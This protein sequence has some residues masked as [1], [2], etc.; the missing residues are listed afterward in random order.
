MEVVNTLGRRKS[1]IA[2]IYVSEGKGNITIN[3][4]EL[5]D[6][7][8][9][10]TLQYIVMQ[11]LNLLEV[12]EKYDI[13]VNLDGGGPKGQAEALRLAISR[14]LI[15]IDAESR[16]QLKAAGFLTRDPREVERKKP[17]QP[18]ARKRFQ[19]SKR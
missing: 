13:K 14:A 19:F 17:G 10:G 11:P 8:P 1:A 12:P 6:Y 9:A 18:K 2:R 4:K 5:K 3:K 16:P 7:F 15:E